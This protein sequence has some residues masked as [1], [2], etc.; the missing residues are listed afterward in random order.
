[1]GVW[2]FGKGGQVFAHLEAA[3]IRDGKLVAN[4]ILSRSRA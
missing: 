4:N 2:L 3:A 1:V